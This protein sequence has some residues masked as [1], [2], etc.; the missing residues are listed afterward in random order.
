MSSS[1]KMCRLVHRSKRG[2]KASA[3][4]H[5]PCECVSALETGFTLVEM[6]AVL[7]ILALVMMVSIP[8]MMR[9]SDKL[10]LTQTIREIRAALRLTRSTAIV[11]G[12]EQVFVIDVKERVYSSYSVKHQSFSKTL[13][14]TFKLAE[15]E[16]QS[17]YRGGIRFFPDGSSTGGEIH[18]SLNERKASLC[19]HWLTGRSV[20]AEHC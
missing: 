3:R 6:L 11:T 19:I 9:P 4:L 5:E 8:S 2:Q 13:E 15:P 16:R 18:F 20:E 12:T 10:V 7:A 17:P 14:A 1:L